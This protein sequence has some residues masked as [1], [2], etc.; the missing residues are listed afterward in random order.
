MAP[1][2]HPRSLPLAPHGGSGKTRS[3]DE[4]APGQLSFP[5]S[6]LSPQ[7]GA[8]SIPRPGPGAGLGKHTPIQSIGVS[9]RPCGAVPIR[10][11][12]LGTHTWAGSFSVVG[13][14]VHHLMFSITSGLYPPVPGAAV[15]TPSSLPHGPPQGCW[16]WQLASYKATDARAI[17]PSDLASE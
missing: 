11:L 7:I 5:K 13:C 2:P 8:A 6:E 17:V 12:S 14:S 9:P 1:N 10:S 15:R 4:P 16:A 3:Q